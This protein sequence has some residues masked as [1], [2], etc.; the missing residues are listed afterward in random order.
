MEK[1]EPGKVF[2]F[3]SE[4]QPVEG[5]TISE[6]VLPGVTVFSLG[7]NTDISAESYPDDTLI[8]VY[9]GSVKIKGLD[10]VLDEGMSLVVKK[11]T[12]FGFEAAA[13][14]V[15]LETSVQNAEKAEYGK[16]LDLNQDVPYSA[17]QIVN[18]DVIHGSNMK[19]A[20]LAFEK[21][22]GLDEHSAPADAI[23]TGLDG[24]GIIGYEG[25]EYPLKKGQ[26][27]RFAKGGRHYVKA[28]DDHFRMSLLL[29]F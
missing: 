13:D 24:N 2:S 12:N 7:K 14:T 5:C 9:A 10:I 17:G 28:V 1:Y 25:N 4:N 16:A 6:K 29:I 18:R 19:Y 21:G 26:S 11:D 27:F 8:Y 3:V 15:L 20:V 23:V 22:T